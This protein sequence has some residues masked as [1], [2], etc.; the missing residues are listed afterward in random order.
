M[1]LSVNRSRL[2]FVFFVASQMLSGALH[3]LGGFHGSAHTINK[4]KQEEG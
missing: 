2:A 3:F 4:E 1:I